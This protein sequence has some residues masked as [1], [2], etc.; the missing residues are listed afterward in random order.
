MPDDVNDFLK[1]LGVYIDAW[2]NEHFSL[3]DLIEAAA[4]RGDRE[5][6]DVWKRYNHRSLGK[7]FYGWVKRERYTAFSYKI[8]PVSSK[9]EG[10]ECYEK[11]SPVDTDNMESIFDDC[12]DLPLGLMNKILAH[13]GKSLAI[14]TL[15]PKNP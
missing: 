15:A 2:T 14:V 1:R 4:K 3:K 13:F 5:V 11:Q 9:K 12:Q 6:L 8:A 7:W 10:L